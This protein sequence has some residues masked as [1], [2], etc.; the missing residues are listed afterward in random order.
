AK[1]QNGMRFALTPE[2]G[3]IHEMEKV[4]NFV[5]K[6]VSGNRKDR[7][8]NNKHTN[9]YKQLKKSKMKNQILAD[10]LMEAIPTLTPTDPIIV[11]VK[12]EIEDDK[13]IQDLQQLNAAPLSYNPFAV[14]LLI[15]EATELLQSCIQRRTELKNLEVTLLTDSINKILSV[16]KRDYDTKVINADTSYTNSSKV[17]S[18]QS[19]VTVS[20][21][22]IEAEA[23]S[24]LQIATYETTIKDA[25]K[26][27]KSE[28]EKYEDILLETSQDPNSGINYLSRYIEVKEI[29]W[30]DFKEVFRK[31]KCLEVGFKTVY[32]IDSPLPIISKDSLL[33]KYYVWL[34]NNLLKLSKVLEQEQEFTL[35]LPL[36]VGI[37]DKDSPNATTPIFKVANFDTKRNSGT[38]DFKIPQNILNGKKLFRIRSIGAN[39]R[40]DD[41]I[42]NAEYW[43][44]KVNLPKQKD[45]SGNT[46]SMPELTISCNNSKDVSYDNQVKSLTYFNANP[47]ITNDDWRIQ[48]PAFSSQSNPRD[49]I[50]DIVLFI[51]IA[52]I[53]Q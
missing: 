23:N 5:C 46:Y 44:I 28:N 35:I 50:Q 20:S 30:E 27:L 33:N 16:K 10:V 9:Q 34:K 26:D 31:L 21:T 14:E 19:K 18:K 39:I 11:K 1:R 45:S 38:I 40:R 42:N 7:Q 53:E 32:E 6:Q 52:L 17:L 15:N 47:F 36:N 43:N 49:Q 8:W 3:R 41:R 24:V 51:R 22:N 29:Y 2:M 37:F 48:V 12:K 4:F 25:K 13:L